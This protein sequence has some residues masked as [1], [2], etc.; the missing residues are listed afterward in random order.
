MNQEQQK[1]TAYLQVGKKIIRI[2]NP[3][4]QVAARIVTT[5]EHLIREYDKIEIH[6]VTV[7][8]HLATTY[9]GTWGIQPLQWAPKVIGVAH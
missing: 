7:G 1:Q 8:D 6:W 3:P 9:P 5:T 2:G 4:N